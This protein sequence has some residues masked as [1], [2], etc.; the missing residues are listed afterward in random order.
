MIKLISYQ[1]DLTPGN[2][3]IV[4][5]LIKDEHV[6]EIM[7]S[8]LYHEQGKFGFIVISGKQSGRVLFEIPHEGETTGNAIKLRWLLNYFEKVYA[9]KSI[10][11]IY[12]RKRIALRTISS[13]TYY[14]NIVHYEKTALTYGNILRIPAVYPYEEFIELIVSEF[15][16]KK[17]EL[18]LIILSGRRAG[19][20]LVIPPEESLV[21]YQNGLGILIKWLSENWNK[22]VYQDS[23]FSDVLVKRARYS[24]FYLK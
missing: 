19:L 22:W 11:A 14:K 16:K 3:L 21:P 13:Q 5:S 20:I 8:Q 17:K 7:L 4:P 15:D 24:H 12:I 18:C 10:N 1:N 6:T 2:I 23:C 9:G